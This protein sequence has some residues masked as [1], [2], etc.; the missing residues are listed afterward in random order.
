MAE[1]ELRWPEASGTAGYRVSIRVHGD[2]ESLFEADV[3][4][5][6]LHVPASA[7]AE[8]GRC[9][10]RVWTR[11]STG[12]PWD[13]YL[14][15]MIVVDEQLAAAPAVDWPEVPSAL[16]YRL[17][18]RDDHAGEVVL[19][20]GF[21]SAPGRLDFGR[22]DHSHLHRVRVQA[23]VD[24]A[25]SDHLP[26]RQA[27]VP[28]E[29]IT[30]EVLE[31]AC[32]EDPEAVEYRF[33]LRA[34]RGEMDPI[35]LQV[36]DPV[37][38]LPAAIVPPGARCEWQVS[39]R[40]EADAEW[41]PHLPEIVIADAELLQQ[42]ALTW[43]EAPEALAYRVVIRDDELDETV[44]KY[45]FLSTEGRVDWAALDISH[46]HRVRV[47]AWIERQWGDHVRYRVAFPPPE[48]LFSP[49]PRE[50]PVALKH[51]V[52]VHFPA[53]SLDSAYG[54]NRPD[55]LNVSRL[56]L[57]ERLTLP[58]LE[59]LADDGVAWFT[60]P[61]PDLPAPLMASLRELCGD[62]LLDPASRPGPSLGDEG[63]G[64]AVLWL[65]AGD[66]LHPGVPR[67]VERRLAGV[68]ERQEAFGVAF[69]LCVEIGPSG[70]R[71]AR[72]PG[73]AAF[74]VVVEPPGR[75]V[76]PTDPKHPILRLRSLDAQVQDWSV[77][78]L[79]R[80]RPGPNEHPIF[81]RERGPSVPAELLAQIG[82]GQAP[83]VSAEGFSAT[84]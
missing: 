64:V 19:K 25:W 58:S 4:E 7:L 53:H 62:R 73:P 22:L 59:A 11:S 74:V 21:I 52:V 40:H 57:F 30:G 12:A 33:S 47:Q 32:P 2:S 50:G 45:G 54:V 77:P 48:L 81:L 66:A 69:P 28:R 36:P 27:L 43:P 14:P 61:D 80:A 84:A 10:W 31:L 1:V 76:A 23:W 55:A 68:G 9:E 83:G 26:Y 60:V 15:E 17:V 6:V 44:S 29:L 56:R 42:P 16:A 37:L 46:P 71:L 8:A 51:L 38:H 82:V 34:V 78:A 24:G 41:V 35:E 65:T 5:P 18:V 3:S 13:L 67:A 72:D 70:G 63:E 79:L 75:R 20:D 39:V 49:S